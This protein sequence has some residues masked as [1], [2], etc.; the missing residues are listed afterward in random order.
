MNT[1]S[2]LMETFSF[3]KQYIGSFSPKI[4]IVLGSGLDILTKQIEADI[5]LSYS[6]LPG[7]AGYRVCGGAFLFGRLNGIPVVCL[8][9]RPHYYEGNTNI[10]MQMPM[11]ILKL[12]GCE[13]VIL[14]NAAGSLRKEVQPGNL[15]VISDHIN[16]QFRNPLVGAND[17]QF[18]P[19]FPSLQ[20]AYDK[21]LRELFL[22]TAAEHHMT[23]TEGVYLATLGPSYET[24]AEIKAFKILGADVVGMSTVSEVIV[25]RHCG[26]KVLVISTITNMASGMTDECLTHENVLKVAKNATQ[27]LGRLLWDFVVKL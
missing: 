18:G 3:I 16:F 8:L 6:E 1:I 2:Q 5:T 12:L 15:V 17:E 25:A 11:R 9:G 27:K 14:T 20:N 7:F 19:R 4:A 23:L 24:P 21:D 13:V 10:A 26:L 22:R